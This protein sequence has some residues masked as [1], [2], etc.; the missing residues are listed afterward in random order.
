M[1]TTY[2]ILCAFF[3]LFFI[4]YCYWD[5]CCNFLSI[6]G[7]CVGIYVSGWF[8][9]QRINMEQTR[10]FIKN[11]FVSFHIYIWWNG[12]K[13]KKKKWKIFNL[14]LNLKMFLVYFRGCGRIWF[15]YS[16]LI[17]F[18]QNV[19]N[20]TKKTKKTD[21]PHIFGNCLLIN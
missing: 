20:V 18:V 6:F 5:C 8:L 13:N 15:L 21:F 3:R 1:D 9:S 14:F 10:K 7:L 4:H 11:N 19:K 2:R 17:W 12:N 16:T